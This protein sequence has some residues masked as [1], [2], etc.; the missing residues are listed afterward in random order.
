MR[1]FYR[2][3]LTAEECQ[4]FIPFKLSFTAMCDESGGGDVR[5]G[6]ATFG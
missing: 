4:E 5:R 1:K 3:T 6:T 2:V